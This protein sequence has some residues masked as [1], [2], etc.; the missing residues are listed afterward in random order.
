MDR[1]S[2]DRTSS[3]AV[4]FCRTVQ[5]LLAPFARNAELI[6]HESVV[7]GGIPITLKTP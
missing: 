5:S 2:M 6:Q 4:S 1:I 7:L 3:C